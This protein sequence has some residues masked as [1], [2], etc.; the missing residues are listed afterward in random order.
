MGIEGNEKADE[1]A[2][3]AAIQ[4]INP[5]QKPSLKSERSNLIHQTIKRQWR[6][7]WSNGRMTAWKLRNMTRRPNAEPGPQIYNQLKRRHIA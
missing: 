5:T 3:Q 2:K 4:R 1:A 6:E 7:Q